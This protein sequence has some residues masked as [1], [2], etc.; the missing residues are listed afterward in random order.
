MKDKTQK[1]KPIRDSWVQFDTLCCGTGWDEQDLQRPQILIDDVFGSSHPGSF[2]L[3]TLAEEASIGVYQE[4]GKPASF[5]A[6]DICDGWAM[7]HDGMNFVLASREV[8]CD[9]VEVHGRVIPWDGMVVIS[10]CDKSISAHLMAVSRLNIPAVHIPGGSNRVGP[11]MSHSLLV[12]E[13]ATKMRLGQ[14]IP[15]EIRNY[16]L[17]G[18]P[19]FGACQFMGTASTMQCMSEALGMAMPG[20]ALQNTAIVTDGRFSG[21]TR[22]PCIGH[23]SPEA[24]AGGPIAL[25]E[26][27]DLIAIDI[28]KRSLN[29][30][31]LKNKRLNS[32]AVQSLLA[33]RKKQWAPPVLD[34]PAGILKR[35]SSRAA[36]AIKGAYLE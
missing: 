15:A 6:T 26:D 35:C 17:S 19:G 4:G 25:V 2:H 12:G 34:H 11:N 1:S 3:D 20:T 13:L 7:S 33:D 9:L 18:C 32:D 10:S 27:D 16:K 31:G 21:A 29:M 14:A 30:V 22:G 8:L 36:S 5:H 28:P 24:V 23:V